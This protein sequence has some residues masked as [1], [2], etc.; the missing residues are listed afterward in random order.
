MQF[1]KRLIHFQGVRL[2]E[3]YVAPKCSPSRWAADHIYEAHHLHI[4]YFNHTLTRAALM[5][6]VYPWRLGRQRGAIERFQVRFFYLETSQCVYLGNWVEHKHPTP[7]R[8]PGQG[9]IQ[10]QHGEKIMILVL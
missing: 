6:G 8:A 2:E 5:T 4:T 7:P 3:S 9:W 10:D 1:Y